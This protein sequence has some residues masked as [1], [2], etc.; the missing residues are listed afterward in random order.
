MNKVIGGFILKWSK[1]RHIFQFKPHDVSTT[2]GKS[3]E[4]YRRILLTGG[5]TFIV[6]MF[7]AIINLIT[8]P[9]TV[10]Y[11]GAERYG[12]WMAIS[13]VMALMSFADLGL[14]N[15][16][17]NAVSKAHG[18][19]N[20]D[21]A[22][23]AVSSTFYILAGISCLLLIIFISIY[24]FIS[25]KNIFNV[26]SPLAIKECGPTMRILVIILL[27]NMPL[28]IIE[29][30]QSG[31][32]EGYRFQVWLIFGSVLSFIGLINLHLF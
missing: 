26:T 17:L 28:G 4:R 29:R 2:A 25:W 5:S 12:L 32:Q 10:N 18:R 15:G 27:I 7:T 6:K 8:V 14:G 11:L 30:I 24:P 3:H 13:S 21:E 22:K 1:L 23:V 19:N 16:L 31:Y 20:R 9:L